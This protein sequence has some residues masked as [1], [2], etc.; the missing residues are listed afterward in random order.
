MSRI[1]LEERQDVPTANPPA[2]SY[3]PS[4]EKKELNVETKNAILDKENNSTTSASLAKESALK[5]HTSNNSQSKSN[6][7]SE[8]GGKRN[9]Y[10]SKAQQLKKEIEAMRDLSNSGESASK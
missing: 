3:R 7:K 8:Q 10:E 2:T 5:P 4:S 1:S 9:F 6:P